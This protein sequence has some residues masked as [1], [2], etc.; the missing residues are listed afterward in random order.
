M[1][2]GIIC[3]LEKELKQLLA[4]LPGA[5]QR[6]F[7]PFVF[8]RFCQNGNELIVTQSGIAKVNAAACAVEL[9]NRFAQDAIINSGVAGG[10]NQQLNSLDVI[11]GSQY[12]HH[13]V[14]CGPEN[15]WGQVQGLPS[16]FQGDKNLLATA[17][18]LQQEGRFSR[19]VH[20]GLICTGEQFITD[21]PA[22]QSI[23]QRF[24]HALACETASGS[25]AQVCYMYQVPFLSFRIISDV[26]GKETNN[27]QQY[28]NFW[29]N[30][31]HA[32]FENTWTFVMAVL[33]GK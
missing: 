19:P 1:K 5:E 21:P 8:Y 17:E 14:F 7:G 20:A 26:V 30:V 31:A 16:F 2:I 32:A 28:E 15:E 18:A 33:S 27:A 23:V 11:A 13:D 10:L 29:E 9:I 6:K 22:L 3:A 12:V 24:P 25:F 4:R